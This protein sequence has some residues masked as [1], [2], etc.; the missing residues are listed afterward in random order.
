MLKKIFFT[1]F[2]Y[3][4]LFFP[5]IIFAAGPLPYVPGAPLNVSSEGS[6]QYKTGNYALDDL[7]KT[8]IIYAEGTL[9]VV[10]AFTLFFIIIGGITLV[11]SAGNQ[12]MIER[13]RAIIV[14]S[15]IG[16]LVVLGSYLIIQLSLSTLGYT[17]SS[18][19]GAGIWKTN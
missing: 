3:I 2:F 16:L 11:I 19:W 7:V 1:V 13:G 14:N 12:E 18:G 8:F 17:G 9:T 5:N 15:I 4:F 6:E 10:G